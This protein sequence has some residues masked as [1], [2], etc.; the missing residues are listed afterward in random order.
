MSDATP[1]PER[2]NTTSPHRPTA[3]H[4]F[5]R[6]LAII[7]PPI[8]TVVILVWAAQLIHSYVVQPITSVVRYSIARGI[9]QIR[10]KEQLADNTG[11]PPIPRWENE[12]RITP[13]LEARLTDRSQI[14]VE[15][16]LSPRYIQHIYVPLSGGYVPLSDYLYVIDRLGPLE[17]ST[18]AIG[19][20]EDLASTK[21]FQSVWH[22]SAVA[23]MLTVVALYFLGRFVT[24]RVGAWIVQ[25]SENAL[26]GRVPLVRNVYSSVKQVTDFLLTERQFEYRR[27][28]AIEYPSRGLWSIGFVTGDGLLDTSLASGEQTV[29]VLIPTSP[30]PMT[31]FTVLVPR[32]DVLDLNL[33][34][35]QAFQ[36]CISCGV[37][38]PPHQRVSPE[39]L[40]REFSNRLSRTLAGDGSVN[41]H[42]LTEKQDD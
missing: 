11:L 39:I 12:Y 34:L 26:L 16:L 14:T 3:M 37:L 25:T 29:S 31:G 19:L 22:L 7:L 20:Y 36:F 9:N 35:D 21:Y 18:T 40:R 28:V 30:L 1:V 4:F 42:T 13:A 5:L 17:A 2:P 32:R 15:Q 24:A 23:V 10:T 8:L 33:T 38:V 6:G 41:R 27:V